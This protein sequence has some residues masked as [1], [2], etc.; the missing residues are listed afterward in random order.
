M[1]SC[2][3]DESLLSQ[4]D[5]TIRLEDNYETMLKGYSVAGPVVETSSADKSEEAEEFFAKVQKV[6]DGTYSKSDVSTRAFSNFAIKVGILKYSTCGTY[7]EFHYH[8]D[9]QDGGWTNIE[10]LVGA[11]TVDSNG[12]VEWKFCIVPG[13]QSTSGGVVT[14]LRSYGGG[15][16]LLSD[17][18]WTEIDGT[19]NVFQRYHDDEDSNNMNQI[20]QFGGLTQYSN[21]GIGASIFSSNTGLAWLFDGSQN[22]D[23]S[24]N[25]VYGVIAQSTT[26]QY[27]NSRISIDDENSSNK[28]W[29]R[30]DIIYSASLI[31]SGENISYAGIEVGNNTWYYIKYF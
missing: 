21:G 25:F 20:T 2:S 24:L 13:A 23:T 9:N 18:L 17:Y 19:M 22:K 27:Y 26:S 6:L 4:S 28:N 30:H 31:Y 29:S 5:E 16:L 8:Q 11:T 7:P 1:A 3:K 10:G 12:N 14:S 15:V